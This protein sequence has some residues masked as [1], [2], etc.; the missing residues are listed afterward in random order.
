M[1]TSKKIKAALA[2]ALVTAT[3]IVATVGFGS[4]NETVPYYDRLGLFIELVK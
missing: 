4:V 2:A 3:V 1:N